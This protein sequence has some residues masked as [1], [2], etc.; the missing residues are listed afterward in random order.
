MRIDRWIIG[1][2]LVVVA[3]GMVAFAQIEADRPAN[4]QPAA[5]GTVL[6]YQISAYAGTGGG[7]GVHHGCYIVDTQTGEVWHTRTG[8]TAEKVSGGLR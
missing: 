3:M 6:R 1:A 7:G 8:G 4:P 2:F 5:A